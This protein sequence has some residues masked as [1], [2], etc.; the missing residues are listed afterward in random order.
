M[1]G[2]SHA[3]KAPAQGLIAEKRSPSTHWLVV[4]GSPQG[5]GESCVAAAMRQPSSSRTTSISWWY[6]KLSLAAFGLWRQ[7]FS[8]CAFTYG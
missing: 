1:Y 5:S 4:A 3:P 7:D 8:S 2:T 6:T